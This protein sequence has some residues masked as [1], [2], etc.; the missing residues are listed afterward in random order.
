MSSFAQG[1]VYCSRTMPVQHFV[2]SGQLVQA[3]SRTQE[4]TKPQMTLTFD[5]DALVRI[6][7]RLS[8]VVKL[9]VQLPCNVS[10][11]FL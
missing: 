1:Y 6:F 3:V 2:N 4:H 8:E 11:L 7:N 9:H 5:L 10:N